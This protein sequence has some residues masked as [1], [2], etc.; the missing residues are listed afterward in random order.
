MV[1]MPMARSLI[2]NLAESFS[3]VGPI[4]GFSVEAWEQTEVDMA[5]ADGQGPIKKARG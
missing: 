5:P 3:V 2:R 4:G 1:E